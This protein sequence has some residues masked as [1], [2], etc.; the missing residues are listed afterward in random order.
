MVHHDETRI[1]GYFFFL[2]FLHHYG[3]GMP[4]DVVILFVNGHPVL[5]MKQE[6]CRQSGYSGA[7]NGDIQ[8]THFV[9]PLFP[10]P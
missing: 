7:D 2:V 9:P 6:R 4:A 5:S 8:I 3:I 10:E 1:N